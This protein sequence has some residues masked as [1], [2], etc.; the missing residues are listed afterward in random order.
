MYAVVQTGGKQYRVTAGDTFQVEK[1]E[2][3]AGDVVKLER[4]L[5]LMNN[6]KPLL[7]SPTIAGAIVEA[8][9]IK[10]AKGE[11][12]LIFKKKRRHQYRRKNGHRQTLT[13]LHVTNITF[14][15]TSIAKADPKKIEAETKAAAPAKAKKA[16]APKA[17][18]KAAPAKKAS[19]EK[20]PAA[21]KPAA[22]KAK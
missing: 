9:I 5:S 3:N 11:K 16:G 20:K 8:Q 21:K 12:V 22:K 15:G 4:V 6:G 17:E 13:T 2:G 7:G 18:K 10:T 19:A 14:N 1:L